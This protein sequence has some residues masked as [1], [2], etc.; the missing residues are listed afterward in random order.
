M[1]YF[2]TAYF[3]YNDDS[4]Y[5]IEDMESNEFGT[6][7][8]SYNIDY[9]IVNIKNI[10]QYIKHIVVSVPE[11][12]IARIFDI[13]YKYDMSIGIVPISS[14][15][16]LI[17]NL[18]TSNNIK[19]NIELSLR[20]DCKPID[21]LNINGNIVYSQSIIGEVPLFGE[22][23]NHIKS[24]FLKTIIYSI[25]K[26]FSIKLQKFEIT[27]KNGQ[28][29]V[30]AG[31]SVK[32]LNHNSKGFITNLFDF[33]H[34]M[35]DGKITALIISP[36]S[37]YE[38]IQLLTSIF[39][40]YKK[41]KSLPKS[42][43][44]I[45]SESLTIEA[46]S[47]KT[48]TIDN[49]KKIN[50][51]IECQIIPDA[52]KLNASE[53]YWIENE[54]VTSTKETVKTSNLPDANETTK[55]I[56]EH[57]PFITSASEERFKELFQILRNDAKTNKT[58]IILMIL[59]TLLAS[60]GLFANSTA[61]IIGAM[62][63]APLM[64]PIVSI[65][66]G[67][68]RADSNIISD[69]LIKI[70]I[71]I[72]VALFASSMLSFL[73]PN[74]ELTDEMTS[75]INP[76]LLDLGVA[77][78]SGI[79]AAYSKSFKEIAQNLAGVA[80]AVALVP[81]LAVAGIGLGYG[82]IYTFL[83][84]FLLF[85][86][87]LVGIIIAAVITFWL[88]GFSSVVKSKKSVAF[89]FALL[90]AVSFPLYISYDNMIEKYKMVKMIKTHRFIVNNKYI[91]VDSANVILQGDIK[92]LNLELLVRES[93]NKKDLETLNIKIQRLFNEKIFIK[94]QMEY[95]L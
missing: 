92:I 63:V 51:P 5:L 62:L 56:S 16:N 78:L 53:K 30:T 80:I 60:F 64:I 27:T 91:I 94:T 48:I 12:D 20:D 71:G 73:L 61:V 19:E 8:T 34:S 57:I 18:H 45:Q 54:K 29:I 95:I 14:S 17:K 72:F 47:S 74:F 31:S 25:K 82:E 85:F 10:S 41:K 59:S 6:E 1:T 40:N 52:I 28:K 83:G 15:K 35:R 43:G 70:G 58:Y 9:F 4:K 86:T 33:K 75:R 68:L 79:A 76:T 21:L 24:S 39:Q 84:A 50:L 32:I 2:S 23:L 26:F 36:Y 46:S 38:Y 81:P 22:K 69:S 87:N 49:D 7:I 13:A 3:I 77:I 90:V 89:V 37:V 42:I 88:L 11:D 93:L 44:Y 65:S 55:Y 66:M 67:L